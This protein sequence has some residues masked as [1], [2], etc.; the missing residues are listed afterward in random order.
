VQGL[1]LEGLG[2]II[3]VVGFRASGF[4]IQGAGFRAQELQGSEFRV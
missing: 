2:F 3:Q 4:R 1:G